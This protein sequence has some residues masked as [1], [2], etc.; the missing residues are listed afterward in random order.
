MKKF[1]TALLITLP[2][3][4][5]AQVSSFV[6]APGGNVGIA[7][8][9][10]VALF[11]VG[12]GT[13]AVTSAGNVGIATTTPAAL[14][15]VGNGILAVTSAGNVGIGVVAPLYA[16]QNAGAAFTQGQEI[17]GGTMTVQGNAFSVGGSTLIVSAGKVGIRTSSPGASLDVRG[18]SGIT[19]PDS[20][21]VYAYDTIGNT[22]PANGEGIIKFNVVSE[23]VLSEYSTTTS[24]FTAQVAGKYLI[25]GAVAVGSTNIQIG[26]VYGT[27]VYKNSTVLW[28][29][30]N[31]GAAANVIT[32]YCPFGGMVKLSA[33]DTIAVHGTNGGTANI[34]NTALQASSWITITKIP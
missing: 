14:F 21:Y 26:K 2:C 17:V 16:L 30:S 4:A 28:D 7:T 1:L 29:N 22:F 3:F 32:V 34:G 12:N 20:S 19:S 6:N 25:Q 27:K 31:I 24:S 10:P 5:K 13:L 18:A 33:G 11:T 23:D 9:T 15:T 8:T